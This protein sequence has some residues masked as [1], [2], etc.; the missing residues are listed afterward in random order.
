MSDPK[1]M[2]DIVN[3]NL[4]PDGWAKRR[5]IELENENALLKQQKKHARKKFI[6]F[7]GECNSMERYLD[8]D[9]S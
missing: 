2:Q 3:L 7:M 1:T 9:L 8:H 6:S 4:M 5:I